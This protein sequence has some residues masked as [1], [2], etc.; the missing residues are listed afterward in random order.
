MAALAARRGQGNQS[1]ALPGVLGPF[2][3]L[4]DT[5]RPNEPTIGELA[6][7]PYSVP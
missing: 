3:P 6:D 7:H 5:G 4:P 1:M 2:P